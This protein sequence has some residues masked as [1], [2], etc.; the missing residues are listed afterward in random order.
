MES[1]AQN[2]FGVHCRRR[3]VR[4]NEV[5]EKVPK[6]PEK[7]WETLVQSQ[8]R[9]NRV[10]EK[11]PEKV[12]RSLRRRFCF[13]F[14]WPGEVQRVLEIRRFRRRL[15]RRFRR[16]LFFSFCFHACAHCIHVKIKRC[17]CWEYHRSLFIFIYFSIGP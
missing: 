17:G 8:V 10:P 12:W 6:V 5:P 13:F 7:V 14:C 15:Q 4:F 16:S 1:S 2:S 3:R 9:F 11:V